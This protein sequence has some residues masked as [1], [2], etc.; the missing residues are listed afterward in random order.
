VVLTAAAAAGRQA[1]A[2]TTFTT[3]YLNGGTWNTIYA[4]GFSPS[5]APSPAPGLAVGDPVL[6]SDF[7]FFK[8]GNADSASNVRLAITNAMYPNLQGLT[9]SSPAVVGLSTNTIV[10]TAG[11]ATGAP[12]AFAF[13]NLPLTYGSDYGAILVNVGP[14]GELT[15]VLVSALTANY[16]ET[17]TGSGSY[18]PQTNYGT[19]DQFQYTVSNFTTTNPFG[20]FFNAFSFAGDANFIAT[21]STVPEPASG[22]L[23][24]AGIAS[25]LGL[26][27]RRRRRGIT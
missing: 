18:H 12:I 27:R 13:N 14:N 23:T 4:Q 2:Q 25:A 16:V 11:T 26:G 8:S 19:E 10:S 24:L 6:L 9:T 1:A 17:P 3:S 15:P 20:T 22:M 21:L 7:R 5:L